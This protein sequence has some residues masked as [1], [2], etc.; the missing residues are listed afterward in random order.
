[1]TGEQR[2]TTAV[3]WCLKLAPTHKFVMPLD[4][5]RH[6][7]P[8]S[9]SFKSFDMYELPPYAITSLQHLPSVGYQQRP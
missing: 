1:M 2:E 8:D 9:V 5:P 4:V 7:G 6:M 3:F